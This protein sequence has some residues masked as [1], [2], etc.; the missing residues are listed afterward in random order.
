MISL[1][2]TLLQ[3]SLAV[4]FTVSGFSSGGF[5]T[6]QLHVAY[7]SYIDAVAIFAGGPYYCAQ[8]KN[9]LAFTACNGEPS[10][11]ILD[12]LLAFASEQAAAGSIDSLDGLKSDKLWIFSG[13]NDTVVVQG[14]VNQT[15]NFYSEFLD[16]SAIM[17]NFTSGAAH[18]WATDFYG[19]DCYYLGPPAVDNCGY[20]AAGQFL[21]F[22]YGT[23]NAKGT[24][25]SSNLKAF[26]QVPYT[27]G[28]GMDPVGYI[29]VPTSCQANPS[30]CKVHLSFHGCLQGASNIGTQFVANTGI[31]QWAETNSLVVIYPQAANDQAK[32]QGGCWDFWGYTGPDYWSRSGKQ[33]G[34]CW[35]MAQNATAII[36]GLN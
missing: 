25:N 6:S 16:S 31:N 28:A 34:A 21:D 8:G 17:T 27:Q 29:Y 19:K 9:S 11:I 36:A 30:S 4:N 5:M 12:S 35:R 32:N 24:Y 14:V 13:L 18:T 2:L 23:L 1:V 3:T 7:S 10:L 33:V 26:S 20:D 22:F 15:L